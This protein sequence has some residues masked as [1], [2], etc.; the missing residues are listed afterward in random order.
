MACILLYAELYCS[1]QACFTVFNRKLFFWKNES[2]DQ[3]MLTDSNP[4]V[5]SA[6]Y[7]NF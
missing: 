6:M 5:L 3:I 1:K 7:E 2:T 4:L